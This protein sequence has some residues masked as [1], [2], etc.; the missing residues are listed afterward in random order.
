ML[1][2][3]N[4]N[5]L[6]VSDFLLPAA[7]CFVSCIGGWGDKLAPFSVLTWEGAAQALSSG[8]CGPVG[9]R[10]AVQDQRHS[11][12]SWIGDWVSLV[13]HKGAVGQTPLV[14]RTLSLHSKWLV[15]SL[16][17][18]SLKDMRAWT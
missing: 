4:P 10:A 13:E 16:W 6:S 18:S 12:V 9:L 1:N 11:T 7:C 14:S 8:H 5:Q 2:E 15:P 17:G 3:T